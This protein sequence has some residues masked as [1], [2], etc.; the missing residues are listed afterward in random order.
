MKE[1]KVKQGTKVIALDVS[2]KPEGI[3]TK[4]WLEEGTQYTVV[5]IIRAKIQN[6]MGFVL[7]EIQTNDPLFFGYDVARFG[8][9]IHEIEKMIANKEVEV[10]ERILEQV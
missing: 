3:K 10:E 7:E 8:I 9:S 4:D 1:I 5:K 2:G 6:K